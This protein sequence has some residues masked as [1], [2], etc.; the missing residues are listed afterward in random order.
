MARLSAWEV[1]HLN[2]VCKFVQPRE[3]VKLCISF[4]QSM[5]KKNISTIYSLNILSFS[6]FSFIYFF[7][8]LKMKKLANKPSTKLRIYLE[9]DHLIMYGSSNESSGCVL[10]GALSLKLNKPT[11]LKS[12]SLCF[13]GKISVSWNQ[14]KDN[15]KVLMKH[16]VTFYLLISFYFSSGKWLRT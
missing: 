16:L 7:L 12:L 10:R 3:K 8:V 14:C 11:R 1:S 13:L 2:L 6:L 5:R 15:I 9:N 4:C